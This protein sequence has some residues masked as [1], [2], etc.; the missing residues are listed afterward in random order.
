M[1][2]EF[3]TATEYAHQSIAFLH[4]EQLLSLHHYLRKQCSLE[5]QHPIFQMQAR[6][7]LVQVFLFLHHQYLQQ[8][9]KNGV[10][11]YC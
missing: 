1:S 3:Q 11:Q 2:E 8:H 10:S 7:Y 5:E 4:E 6:K 9:Q